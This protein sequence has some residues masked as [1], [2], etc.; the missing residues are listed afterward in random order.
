MVKKDFYTFIIK[1]IASILLIVVSI[2]YL[3]NNIFALINVI[4]NY[5]YKRKNYKTFS[6]SL[7]LYELIS[8]VIII[9]Q[10]GIEEEILNL[11]YL[12]ILLGIELVFVIIVII[13]YNKTPLFKVKLSETLFIA[14]P[15][16]IIVI[17]F[18]YYFNNIT[19]FGLIIIGSI[20][21]IL[22]NLLTF[23]K[24][25]KKEFNN[26]NFYIDNLKLI[27]DGLLLGAILALNWTKII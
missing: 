9:I 26:D 19:P 1:S 15:L 22:S 13:K 24:Y 10:Y 18:I 11:W 6:L 3:P 7:L 8:S 21:I 23:S 27:Y 17:S 16:Y 25:Y 12:L 4:F 20:A 2:F 5:F 14:I